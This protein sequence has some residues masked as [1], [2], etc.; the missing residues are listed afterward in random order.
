MRAAYIEDLAVQENYLL[1]GDILHHLVMVTRIEK[2]EELLLLNGHGLSVR[3]VVVEA[4]KKTLKLRKLSDSLTERKLVYDLAVGIPKKEA[5]EL[6]LKQAVE[7]GFRC[8]YLVRGRYS[9]TRIPEAERVK[10]LMISALEQSNCL[11]LPEVI[12]TSWENVSWNDYGTVLLLDSQNGK[13]E[14]SRRI[15]AE[16][17]L[18]VGPEG[19]FSPEEV[20]YLRLRP[21]VESILLPTPILR[22]PTA[23]AAGA[24]IVLQRLMS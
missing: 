11:W 22:T 21:G 4:S 19:G 1:T 17:L 14:S 24:G 15:S 7:L 23:I 8:I 5:L 12:E 16:N 18:V 3:T 20:E 10:A 9:Q 13:G 6:S 2:D